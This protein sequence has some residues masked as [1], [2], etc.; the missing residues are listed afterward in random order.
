MKCL[1]PKH[2]EVV[3]VAVENVVRVGVEGVKH[4]A[5]ED[6]VHVALEEVVG[7][8]GQQPSTSIQFWFARCAKPQHFKHIPNVLG[9][10]RQPEGLGVRL[11]RHVVLEL[12][13]VERVLQHHQQRVVLPVRQQ[14]RL[15][16]AH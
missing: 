3:H 4:V 1:L 2:G 15:L 12:L 8:V 10:G 7:R 9:V 13:R 6:D 14:V 11:H 5:V 16:S